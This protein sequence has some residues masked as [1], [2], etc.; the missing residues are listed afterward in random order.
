[1]R[2]IAG[3]WRSRRLARPKGDTTRPM[4]DRVKEAIFSMLGVHYDTPGALPPLHVADLFAGSGSLGLEA[5]SRG[6][7]ACCFFERDVGALAAL[8]CNLEALD[9]DDRATVL[10]HDAWRH[11]FA[12]ADGHDFDLIFLDPPYREARDTSPGGRLQRYFAR[13]PRC[14]TPS[15]IIVFHHPADVTLDPDTLAPWRTITQ[16]I[17]GTGAISV[18]AR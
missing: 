3:R 8:R 13:W 6:A 15:D 9:V 10:T 7:A 4:P 14:D 12:T 17:Y 16:R 1:M 18:L 2:I 5:L 11:G